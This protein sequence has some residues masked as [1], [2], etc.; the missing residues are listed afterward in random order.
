MYKMYESVPLV[1]SP[2]FCDDCLHALSLEVKRTPSALAYR[3]KMVVAVSERNGTNNGFRKPK[4]EVANVGKE[5][6]DISVQEKEFNLFD[7]RL[8]FFL[9]RIFPKFP[10]L[11]ILRKRCQNV[12]FENGVGDTSNPNQPSF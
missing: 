2:S 8:L 3:K 12:C 1:S 6:R 4:D 10:N 9:S 11:Y 7:V 5:K